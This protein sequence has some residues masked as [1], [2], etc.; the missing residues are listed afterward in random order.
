MIEVSDL[1]KV[2]ET[3]G[4]K[5]EALRGVDLKVEQGQTIAIEGVSGSG[6]STLLHLMGTLDHPTK[7]DIKYD[8]EDLQNKSD[9]ELARFRNNK[10]GFVFQF[11]YL[12]AEFS[13]LE[14]VMM[15]GLING[16]NKEEAKE[17][18]VKVLNDVG[19]GGRLS[20]RPGELSG[21]EQQRV[22]IARSIVLKP[23]VIFAD[24]PTGNLDQKTGSSIIDLFVKLNIEYNVSIIVVTHNSYVSSYFDKTINLLDG[25]VVYEN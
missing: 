22:A 5:V 6:K 14:N 15:P 4:S 17:L 3:N 16:I 19:L 8:G 2:Y 20:H 12:L 10:I 7:G 23:E 1:W 21:G 25:K 24:E 18:A 13:A 9:S 11:H